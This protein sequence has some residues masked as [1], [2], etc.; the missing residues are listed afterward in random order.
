MGIG[1][2]NDRILRSIPRNIGVAFYPAADIA[3]RI[4]FIKLLDNVGCI[5]DKNP[6]GKR[7]HN[8]LST[9]PAAANQSRGD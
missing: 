4:N 7:E 3:E 2:L 6:G 8:R 9:L 1:I 5:E